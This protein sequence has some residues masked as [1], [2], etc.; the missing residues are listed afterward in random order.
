MILRLAMLDMLRRPGWLVLLVLAVGIASASAAFS[1]S[2][3]RGLEGAFEAGIARAG[4][5]IAIVPAGQGEAF[6]R[7]LV[8][9]EPEAL[10]FAD[11]VQRVRAV[12][13]VESACSQLFVASAQ[14]D[15][16]TAGDVLI[17]AMDS[18]DDFVVSPW[19]RRGTLPVDGSSASV[20]SNLK[21]EIG[22]PITF[23]GTRLLVEG[24]LAPTGWGYFDN[25][26]FVT[27]A[28]VDRMVDASRSD[29]GVARLDV[30]PGDASVVWVRA[31]DDPALVA[32][33]LRA[34]ISGVDVME[35]SAFL[36]R[37]RD[38]AGT[39]GR[40]LRV[41]SGALVVGACLMIAAV[42]VLAVD[43]RRG[44]LAVIR[45]S[46]GSRRG[47]MGVVLLQASAIGFVG[48]LVGGFAGGAGAL[49]FSLWM[50]VASQVPLLP[51]TAG[52][53]VGLAATAAVLSALVAA[54]IAAGPALA[55]AT[56]GVADA[57]R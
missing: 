6:R 9:G 51:P 17:I 31:S 55:A 21:R 35:L 7:V 13:G 10:S 11:P 28:A 34:E 5:D 44:D 48:G 18:A 45:A 27:K 3:A 42:F 1:A 24:A 25:A 16:C 52:Q 56:R 38:S 2:V 54:V 26:S 43:R 39:L 22:L 29:P 19:I 12:E 41:L 49:A 15:C 57:Q 4:A 47:L 46:G 14:A 20:G 8:T 40:G 32:K 53:V 33:R 37:V 36:P 50:S 23:F 30:R